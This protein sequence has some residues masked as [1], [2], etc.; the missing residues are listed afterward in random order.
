MK[1]REK[2]GKRGKEGKGFWFCLLSGNVEKKFG[3]WGEGTRIP[4]F[5]QRQWKKVYIY[6]F[7]WKK[8]ATCGEKSKGQTM[9]GRLGEAND[10]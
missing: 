4:G 6:I 9:T 2:E 3:F 5:L 8:R 1:K 10:S 7:V